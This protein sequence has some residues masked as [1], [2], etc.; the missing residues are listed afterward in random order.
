MKDTYNEMLAWY[1]GL[2]WYW[3]ILGVVILAV[4][5]LL[6]VLSLFTKPADG[7]GQDAL[8][9]VD[10]QHAAAV[11]EKLDGLEE[12]DKEI[13]KEIIRKKKDLARKVNMAND[14]DNA[15]IERRKRIEAATTME[16]VDAIERELGL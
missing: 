11:D 15:T 10:E 8:R 7:G 5:A 4:V 16:E 1:K 13:E 3:K 14:I 9:D 6:W 2:A 12:K